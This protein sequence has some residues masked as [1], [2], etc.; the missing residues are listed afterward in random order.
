MPKLKFNDALTISSILVNR[1]DK[2]IPASLKQNYDIPP[3]KSLYKKTGKSICNYM[4][5]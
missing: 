5:Q 1:F 2:S 4:V 3:F